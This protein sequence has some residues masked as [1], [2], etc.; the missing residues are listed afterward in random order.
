M[1][2][3]SVSDLSQGKYNRYTLVMAAAKG[4]RIVTD[5][6]CE[7]R[8]IAEKMIANKETDKSLAAL[9]TPEY[10]NQKPV[11]TAI[12]KLYEGEYIISNAPSMDGTIKEDN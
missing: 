3:P 9:I 12:N 6:Y 10:R 11:K 4:A 8:S 1:I 5:D 7:Q 2:K